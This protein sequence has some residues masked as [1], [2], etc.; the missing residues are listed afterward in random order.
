M[1]VRF[2]AL[3]GGIRTVSIACSKSVSFIRA[4]NQAKI[5]VCG[6]RYMCMFDFA[7]AN[8]V[9]LNMI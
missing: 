4:M 6:Q 3:K 1:D 9:H 5:P 2:S 8:K 7:T